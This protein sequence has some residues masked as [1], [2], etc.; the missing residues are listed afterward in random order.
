VS[1]ISDDMR[2]SLASDDPRAAGAIHL[3]VYRIG[4]ELG[5]LAAA[6]GELDA[7]VFTG[8]IREHAAAIREQVCKDA[9]WLGIMLDIDANGAGGPCITSRDSRVTAW[10]IPP[11]EDLMIARHTVK[12][13]LN[14]H[15]H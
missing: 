15:C 9:A 14:D 11:D 3:F 1:G 5:S 10:V 4:R 13:P 6:L 2:T 8:G 12:E 7:L